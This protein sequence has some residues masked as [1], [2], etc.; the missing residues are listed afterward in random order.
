MLN[1]EKYESNIWSG[2]R[3]ERFTIMF[4]DFATN[5]HKADYWNQLGLVYADQ[6]HIN[7]QLDGWL[8]VFD[9]A[10]RNPIVQQALMDVEG[11]LEL[12]DSLDDT[13]TVYRG[14]ESK[15]SNED[16]ISWTLDKDK[17][18]WFADRYAYRNNGATVLT[19]TG[20]KEDVFATFTGRKE[21]EVV[22]SST[23]L[24]VV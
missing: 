15:Y 10:K 9:Y 16:S 2:V 18:Q 3:G 13:F 7:D 8:I 17:A 23:L 14:I 19:A 5:M 6:E 12:F 1:E 21:S 24:E 4:E 22:I 20:K 11:D